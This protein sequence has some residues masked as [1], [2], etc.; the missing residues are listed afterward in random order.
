[1]VEGLPSFLVIG[2]VKAATTWISHQLRCHPELWLPDAEPHFFSDDYERG[3]DHYRSLFAPAPAGRR[4]GEKSADYLAHPEAAARIAAVLPG[5]PMVVQL[6]DPVE[7]AYSD[8]CMLFRHGR[9]AGDPRRYLEKRDPAGKRFLD[10]GLYAQ[11]LARFHAHHARDRIAVF[12]YE[13]V[14][15]Q[16][17][18]VIARV[19]EH[20]GVAPHIEPA[21]VASRRNDGAAAMLPLP[22]R[23]VL[24]PMRPLLDPLRSNPLLARL[25]GTMA[26][27]VRY[28]PLTV[29]LRALLR[30]YYRDDVLQ[31]ESMIGRDLSRWR[32][33]AVA[34]ANDDRV[35]AAS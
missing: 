9:V 16:P 19:C 20:I 14:I 34:G 35:T 32:T 3:L 5:V 2:A 33:G 30:D 23:R 7:R 17:E 26:R 13:D 1:M 6:R 4:I 10:G 18:R 29:E 28:P 8:Y 22:V 31:L 27:P 25:R 12:L 15:E 11:H 21:A 24:R